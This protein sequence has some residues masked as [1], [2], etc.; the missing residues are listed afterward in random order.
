MP[1]LGT[2]T[3][4]SPPK[5][6]GPPPDL[7]LGAVAAVSAGEAGRAAVH[8]VMRPKKSASTIEP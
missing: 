8:P 6:V 5:V 4:S 2:P 3:D 1:H 7:G